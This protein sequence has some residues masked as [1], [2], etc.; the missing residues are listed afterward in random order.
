MKYVSIFCILLILACA[1]NQISNITPI[2]LTSNPLV[3][4][5]REPWINSESYKTFSV[6]PKSLINDKT[7]FNNTILEKQMMFALRNRLEAKGYSFVGIDQNP[8]FIATI[9][10][11]ASYH[12]S[13]VPPSSITLPQYVPGKTLT[14]NS[15]DKGSFN[16]NAYGD[17]SLYG[18]GTW[19]GSSTSTID[20]PGYYASNSY[21]LPGYYSGAFYPCITIQIYDG[22][23]FE[24]KWTGI[25]AGSSP[26]SDIRIS[27]QIVIN[28][29]LSEFPNRI[30]TIDGSQ[31]KKGIIGF[32]YDILTI[33][34]NRYYP[35]VISLLP[36]KPA[37]KGGIKRFDII[38]SVDGQS[39]ENRAFSEC[40]QLMRGD[41]G[42][43][44][45]ISVK[46]LD[47]NI[48]YQ[49]V[50]DRDVPSQTK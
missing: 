39:T 8:D 23:S 46:R 28:K 50:R 44:V 21:N 49:L 18:W 6:F 29:V 34:G 16:F 45:T 3:E 48:Q 25:G 13:Y 7:D 2:L 1:S 19:N 47:K 20:I 22:H 24:N 33:D 41:P 10:G 15:Q 14:V 26:K 9:D 40:L 36:D 35:T 42:T 37:E 43:K 27:G 12:E 30:P 4:T 5:Y 32:K 31:L 38:T 11:S 17:Y